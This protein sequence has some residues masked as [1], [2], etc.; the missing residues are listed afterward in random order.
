MLCVEF[1]LDGGEP[2]Y[3]DPKR[4][5]FVQE[6]RDH[7]SREKTLVGL[8]GNH[9]TTID[10]TCKIVLDKLAWSTSGGACAM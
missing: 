10:E 2:V 1:N 3:I 9:T 7:M 8:D 5:V 4:V 6:Y